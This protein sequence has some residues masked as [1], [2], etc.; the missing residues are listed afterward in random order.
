MA[1]LPHQLCDL[2]D[3]GRGFSPKSHDLRN[4]AEFYF[5]KRAKGRVPV[6]HVFPSGIGL[7]ELP[8]EEWADLS[9][10]NID[11]SRWGLTRGV[12]QV[13][14]N[15]A[16]TSRGPWRLKA[17]IDRG[18]RAVSKSFVAVR[19]EVSRFAARV[20]LGCPE[21]ACGKFLCLFASWKAR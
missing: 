7:H 2:A 12:P 13:L 19:P 4:G 20:P 9:E 6:Y 11:R 15:Y 8:Q 3:V 1:L 18:G 21:L 14:F 5:D 17:L 10:E 16:S